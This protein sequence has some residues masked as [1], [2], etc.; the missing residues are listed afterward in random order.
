VQKRLT[1]SNPGRV[2]WGGAALLLV[3]AMGCTEEQTLENSNS[4]EPSFARGTSL[5]VNLDQCANDATPCAWQNGDLNGNNSAFAEGDVVPFRLAIEGL[6]PGTHSVHINYDFTAGGHKAYDFLAS[7]DASETVD[8]CATGGG[9]VSS[10]C[11]SSLGAASAFAWPGDV[12]NDAGD[13]SGTVDA[14]ISDAA[15]ALGANGR[16]LRAYGGTIT[17]IS[18]PVHSGNVNGNSAADM[19]VTFTT[20]GNAVLLVWG[21][22]LGKSAFWKNS[23]QSADGAGE[24]SGAPWHMRTQQLDGAGNKNQDRSIQPSAITE[25]HPSLSLSKSPDKTNVC[26]DAGTSV[27]YTYV[28]TNTGD[29]P[30]SGTVTDDN[31]TPAD[32]TDDFTVGSFSNLAPQGTQT[33]TRSVAVNSTT[34]NIATASATVNTVTVTATAT[35][36][37]TAQTCGI[38]LSKTPDKTDVCTN[39]NNSV[40]Y[41]YVVTNNSTGGFTASGTVTDDNGTPADATDDFTVGSFTNVAA[42]GGTQTLTKT[43]TI[44]TNTTNTATASGTVNGETVTATASATVSAHTCSLSLSKTPSTNQVCSGS[45]TSVTYT[46]VITNTGDQF[47]ASGTLVDDNGTPADATD[48]VSVGSWGPIAASGTQTL[49]ST[50]SISATTTNIATASGTSGGASVSATATATVTAVTCGSAQLAPTQTTCEQFAAGSAPDLELLEAG[51]KA[52]KINNISPGVFF[53]F[54]KLTGTGSSMTFG[55]D[56]SNTF[57]LNDFL[58][59]NGQAYVYQFSAGS[60]TRLLTLTGTEPSGTLG[61]T[62]AG[63]T[64]ILGIKYGTDAPVGQTVGGGAKGSLISTYTFAALLGGNPVPGTTD[65]DDLVRK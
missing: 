10:L 59:L 45:G 25:T 32:A 57:P 16:E 20:S 54:A 63:A 39:G 56:Q 7:V 30:L 23:D 50:R 53:Y 18:A 43:L 33:F 60:C 21:G 44:T 58:V 34:T 1:F 35:A 49:T 47:P 52:G 46:Y 55:V 5:G 42:G 38:S 62:T 64:Y 9:G 28:V 15:A 41:T 17:Q 31:G 19:V 61:S 3:L 14:A 2:R 36:T 65:S 26:T 22:H 37:V 4:N 8:L 11:A 51:I 27:T 13:G 48:D 12:Y 40:T 6:T 24:V 29:I